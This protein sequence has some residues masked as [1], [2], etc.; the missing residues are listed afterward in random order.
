VRICVGTPPRETQYA[1]SKGCQGLTAIKV[2]FERL[3]C[4]LFCKA[5]DPEDDEENGDDL[6]FLPV[7]DHYDIDVAEDMEEEVNQ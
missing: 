1:L 6:A 5:I 2:E 7:D 4:D 3:Q